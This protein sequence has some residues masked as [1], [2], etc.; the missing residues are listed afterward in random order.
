MRLD[1]LPSLWPT[2][3]RLASGEQ[4][5]PSSDAAAD[6]LVARANREALLPLL[7]AD[8]GLPAVVRTALDRVRALKRL[9]TRRSDMLLVAARRLGEILHDEPFVFLKGVDYRH[10]LY[11]EPALRPMQDIDILVPRARMTVVSRTL[12]ARGLSL[13]P[14]SV[15]WPDPY[16]LSVVAEL[17]SHHERLFRL[18]DVS[19][20]AHHSFVQRSRNRVDYEA[21][22]NRKVRFVAP[23]ITGYRLA[24]T[25]ALVYH[26]LSMAAEEFSIPLLR[27]IDLWLMV[28]GD[29][30]ICEAAVQL[31]RDWDV[32]RAL[33]GAFRL[34][35]R[36]LPE[37]E[38]LGPG[39]AMRRL[40]S[41]SVR[42]FLD[43]RVLPDPWEHGDGR[44]PRRAV[45]V[46]RKLCLMDGFKHR[47]MFGLYHGYALTRGPLSGARRR[48]HSASGGAANRLTP[49]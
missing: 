8:G 37:L 26:T 32:E 3:H 22:W 41:P 44:E 14:R 23:G 6:R 27:Y 46:W 2:L 13:V 7:F 15:V 1:L 31:A 33:Y 20:D 5:P 9:N 28:R 45:Q 25:D 40:L 49:G 47:A 30:D 38:D 43:R 18:G 17:P 10:R 34:A 29:P 48:P 35:S 21:V 36:L 16:P 4:W 11:Q 24:D 39:R 12:V 42:R 19:V